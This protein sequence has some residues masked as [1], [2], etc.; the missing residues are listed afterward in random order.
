MILP[1]LT[2][3]YCKKSG[4]HGI[5]LQKWGLSIKHGDLLIRNGG[6][7]KQKKGIQSIQFHWLVVSTPVIFH[8]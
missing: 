4:C 6:F 7:Q 3:F 8:P 2:R 5:S 1:D